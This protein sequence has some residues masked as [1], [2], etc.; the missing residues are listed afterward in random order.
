MLKAVLEK[1]ILTKVNKA[2]I[3]KIRLAQRWSEVTGDLSRQ[4]IL[5]KII[6]NKAY[7]LVNNSCLAHEVRMQKEFFLH[8]IAAVA[9][10]G[11]ISDIIFFVVG[12]KK[13]IQKN[14]ISSYGSSQP[15]II[16][17]SISAQELELLKK[18]KSE[19]LRQA[20]QNIFVRSKRIKRLY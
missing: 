10:K 12:V 2:D 5:D 13:I 4:I 15:L 18:I 7:L 9:G 1:F 3:W 6:G 14:L 20:L 8:K 11:K 19:D 17:A 16:D